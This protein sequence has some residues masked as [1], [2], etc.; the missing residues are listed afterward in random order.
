MERAPALCLLTTLLAFYFLVPSSA[1]PLSRV[2]RMTMQEDGQIPSVESS[3]L[4]PKMKM[5]KFVPEDDES[6]VTTRMAFETQDY[7]PPGPNNR[8]KP[9]GWR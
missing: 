1:V 6:M 3:T 2:Q 5:E 7:S 8:H 9:P 4:E